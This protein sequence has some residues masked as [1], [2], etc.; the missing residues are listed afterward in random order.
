MAYVII[1]PRVGVPGAEFDAEA[2]EAAGINIAA[3]IAGGF[4][5]QSTIE[6]TKHAKTNSKNT[7][8]D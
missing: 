3:L 5:E 8:K 7:P 6:T 4:I 1:S 2:A